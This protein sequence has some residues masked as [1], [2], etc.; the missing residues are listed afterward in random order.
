MWHSPLYAIDS[1]RLQADQW[2]LD[3]TFAK[4]FDLSVDLTAQGLQFKAAAEKLDLPEPYGSLHQLKLTCDAFR[5]KAQQWQC[6][7]GTASFSHQQLGE[8]SFHS[9][10]SLSLS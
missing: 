2:T 3:N 5:I 8:Q 9:V 4:Q 1:I 6:E 7:S 10:S